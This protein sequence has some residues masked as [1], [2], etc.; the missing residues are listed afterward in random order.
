MCVC[1]ERK[2]GEG[3]EG[4]GEGK[5]GKG[6]GEEGR[7]GEEEGRER[8]EEGRGNGKRLSRGEVKGRGGRYVYNIKT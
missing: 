6:R 5:V 7:G 2:G 8:G 3:G 4:E 1:V